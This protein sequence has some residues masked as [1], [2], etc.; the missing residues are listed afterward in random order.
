[1]FIYKQ[2]LTCTKNKGD[3]ITTHVDHKQLDNLI[4]HIEDLC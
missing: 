2:R 1:M 3:M 4:I